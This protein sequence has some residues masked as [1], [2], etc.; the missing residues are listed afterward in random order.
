VGG[1]T[2]TAKARLAAEEM[3]NSSQAK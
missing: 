1:A 3:I 2:I